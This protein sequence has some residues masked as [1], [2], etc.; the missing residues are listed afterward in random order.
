MRSK[1]SSES[2]LRALD[3][4]HLYLEA[5]L[6]DLL[7]LGNRVRLAVP[8]IPPLELDI[9]RGIWNGVVSW[10]REPIPKERRIQRVP[11][12]AWGIAAG[13]ALALIVALV[14]IFINIGGGARHRTQRDSQNTFVAG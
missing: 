4:E 13:L 6:Q 10:A 3:G 7:R 12:L 9:R 2:L 11:R 1:D 8:V 5:E 14:F